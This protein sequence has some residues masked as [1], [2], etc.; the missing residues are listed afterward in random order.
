MIGVDII[1]QGEAYMHGCMDEI[2][3]FPPDLATKSEGSS[4]R[5]HLI[6]RPG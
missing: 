1:D 2:R 5:N 4:G 3:M 6:V